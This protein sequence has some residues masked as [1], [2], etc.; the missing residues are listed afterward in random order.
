MKYMGSK[1]RIARD[2]LPIMLSK[3]KL[4]QFWV[5]PFVGG[6]NIID[7]V[8]GNRIGSDLNQ[9]VISALKLIV[10]GKTPANNSE[11]TE[12]DY[13]NHADIFRTGGTPENANLASYA[14]IAFSFGAKWIGGWSR[15]KRSDGSPRDYVEEQHKASEKQ[16]SLIAG[17]DFRSVAYNELIIPPESIIYCDPPYQGTTRYRDKFDNA[18][19]WQWCREKVSDG[20]T[21]FVSEYTS[22]DDFVCI[23]SKDL[24]VSVAR[25]GSHKI[26]TERLFVHESQHKPVATAE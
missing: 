23:W 24:G 2:I 5:E 13:K 19:F 4:G 17:V 26:A 11:Y 21:V 10:D 20:H 12:A 8:D 25:N 14:M 18:A 1:S 9:H 15:G 3:R 6:A 22:P 16:K 7:K